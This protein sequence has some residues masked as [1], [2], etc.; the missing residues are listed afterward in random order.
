M[1]RTGRGDTVRSLDADLRRVQDEITK[2]LARKY[3][4]EPRSWSRDDSVRYRNLCELEQAI[5]AL[6]RLE[7]AA[8]S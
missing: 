8:A 7:P 2:L 4:S 6:Y 3:F 1:S 5:R